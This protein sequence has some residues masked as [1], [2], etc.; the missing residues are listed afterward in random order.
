MS[1]IAMSLPAPLRLNRE[2]RRGMSWLTDRMARLRGETEA[3]LVARLRAGDEQAF[4]KL[5]DLYG[6]MMLRVAGLYVRDRAVAEEVVQ[7]TWLA[8]LNGI[9]RFEG[10][11]SLKT[12]IFRIL[13]NRAKTRAEREGRT[14]PLSAIVAG[15][16]AGG[17]AAVDPDRFFGPD[18]ETPFGWAA[19]PRDWPQRR[20]LDREALKVIGEA[21]DGLP[22]TQ[23]TVIR[24]R[25]VEGWTPQEVAEALEITDGNQR[26]LL[27]RARSKVRAALESYLNPEQRE[28]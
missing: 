15:E 4:E 1:S 25:D 24:L 19:P 6:P 7:E 3:D 26:V 17:E 5:V 10:R 23:A 12:W 28:S 8:V 13:S 27:H 14:V 21:I 9:D 18:S 20:V 2:Y 22:E 11:S 16:A